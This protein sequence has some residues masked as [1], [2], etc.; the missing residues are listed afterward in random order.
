[1]C[2][3]GNYCDSD[4]SFA[5]PVPNFCSGLLHR[6]VQF[7]LSTGQERRLSY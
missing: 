6:L 2:L 5:H 4:E 1:M 3:A 7:M